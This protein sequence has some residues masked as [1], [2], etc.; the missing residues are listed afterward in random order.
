M[1][2][3]QEKDPDLSPIISALKTDRR[4]QHSDVVAESPAVQ[5]YCSIWN[6]LSLQNGCLYREL[7]REDGTGSHLQFIVPRSIRPEILQQM[8]NSLI[9]GHLGQKKTL[10]KLL[11]RFYWFNVQENVHMWLMKCD[12]CAATKHPYRTQSSTGENASG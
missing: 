2:K 9:S 8:H 1:Q 12:I 6:S 7:Y 11:Q 3:L 5:Y 10:E 4:P